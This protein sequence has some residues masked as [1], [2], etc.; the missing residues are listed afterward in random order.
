[1]KRVEFKNWGGSVKKYCDCMKG[2]IC[3]VSL[4]GK[5]MCLDCYDKNI[6][7]MARILGI[8]VGQIVSG[9]I[10]IEPGIYRIKGR[11]KI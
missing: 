6:E 9:D 1:M 3:V 7:V 10:E 11:L 2:N 4:N 8:G 5:W